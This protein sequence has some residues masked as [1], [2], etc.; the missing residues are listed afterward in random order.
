M[1][2]DASEELQQR[3]GSS[4]QTQSLLF[5]SILYLPTYPVIV[6]LIIISIHLPSRRVKQIQCESRGISRI[7]IPYQPSLLQKNT[8]KQDIAS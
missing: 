5:P 7:K 1:T 6:F 2:V 4:L 8:V 3:H